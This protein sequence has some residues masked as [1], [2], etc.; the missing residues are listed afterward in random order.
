M[1]EY[2]KMALAFSS[3][4]CKSYEGQM[5]SQEITQPLW[6]S[7]YLERKRLFNLEIRKRVQIIYPEYKIEKGQLKQSVENTNTSGNK[8]T[9]VKRPAAVRKAYLTK[10]NKKKAFVDY[11]GCTQCVVV[12]NEKKVNKSVCPNCGAIASPESFID[13][14]DFC[15]ARFTV[16]NLGRKISSFNI[17][18]D[19]IQELKEKEKLYKVLAFVAAI[20]ALLLFFINFASFGGTELLS[21]E[22]MLKKIV[23]VIMSV[24]IGVFALSL[25]ARRYINKNSASRLVYNDTL[26]QVKNNVDNFNEEEFVSQLDYQLK[27]LHF[28]NSQ[29]DLSGFYKK[30][31]SGFLKYYQNVIE[32]NL[33]SCSLTKYISDSNY[34]YINADLVLQ[35]MCFE[36]N[37]IVT[38]QEKMSVSLYKNKTESA[39]QDIASYECDCC[40]GSI[41]M[42]N[43]GI[44]EY[45]GKQIDLSL[46]EFAIK[47]IHSQWLENGN[48]G[49]KNREKILG[50]II[51]ATCVGILALNSLKICGIVNAGMAS[52]ENE[53]YWVYSVGND[54]VPSFNEYGYSLYSYEKRSGLFGKKYCYEF[55]EDY[56]SNMFD[57][58]NMLV[59]DDG[60]E[61]IEETDDKIILQRD[62]HFGLGKITLTID[63]SQMGRHSSK[64][65]VITV[66]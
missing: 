33:K 20:L 45:C 12:E 61:I 54:I 18:H 11:C 40:G 8:V 7:M 60:F 57:Y 1:T 38:R 19:Y 4:Y 36:K 16:K 31:C 13:G 49:I 3:E 39:H 5:V 15:N 10:S 63:R 35:I 28:A 42:L 50:K 41:N 6:Y 29:K 26:I 9:L 58:A 64:M 24:V 14:C 21:T 22:V 25:L 52:A 51:V 43:G 27:T 59:A 34:H 30:D 65:Y 53:K 44:C 55:V 17:F 2:E 62:K 46:H 56:N 32:C 47:D 48:M 23:Q 66:E 37:K